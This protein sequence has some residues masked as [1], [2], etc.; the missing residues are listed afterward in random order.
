MN[1]KESQA[2][3]MVLVQN[4]F[5]KTAFVRWERIVPDKSDGRKTDDSEK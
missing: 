4:S 1:V 5:K 3:V 2:A